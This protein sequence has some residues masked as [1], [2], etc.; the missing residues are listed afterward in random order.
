M[1]KIIITNILLFFLIS[2]GSTAKAKIDAIYGQD[3]RKEVSRMAE[4]H[5]KNASRSVAA[6]IYSEDLPFDSI[7][8]KYRI[9]KKQYDTKLCEDL[10]FSQQ[11]FIA[12]CTGFLIHPQLVVTAGH[13]IFSQEDCFNYSWVFDY[14]IDY[15]QTNDYWVE[16]ANVYTCKKLQAR[17]LDPSTDIDFAIIQ[18]DRPVVGRVPLSY[19]KQGSIVLG[20]S[21]TIIGHP[22]G[23]PLKYSDNAMVTN[24]VSKNYFS[25]NLDSFTGNS[26]SPVFNNK[27]FEVEGLLVRGEADFI[28]N[29]KKSCLDL[30]RCSSKN[31]M[32]EEVVRMT[33]I[34]SSIDKAIRNVDLELFK[35]TQVF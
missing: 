27:S 2:T 8:N 35:K 32:G 16:K 21:I 33:A 11:V 17:E 23:V 4:G 25:S 6:I 18:L 12:G 28:Y 13:C 26:G 19:R 9:N 34:K 20:E 7:I 15:L 30:K 31:C 5:L 1:I 22:L 29:R 24:N 3:D 10:P 14:E